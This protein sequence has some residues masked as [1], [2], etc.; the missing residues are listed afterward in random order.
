MRDYKTSEYNKVI[1]IKAKNMEVIDKIRGKKSKAGKL[2]E[3]IEFYLRSKNIC[4]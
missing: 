4:Q 3:I 2:N 1:G